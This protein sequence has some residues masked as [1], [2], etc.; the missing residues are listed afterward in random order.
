[1]K[2]SFLFIVRRDGRPLERRLLRLDGGSLHAF[3]AAG[4]LEA[5]FL[6]LLER[7]VSVSLDFGEMRKYVLTAIV[8]RYESEAFCIVE[9]LHSTSCHTTL[10]NKNK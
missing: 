7:L 3:W 5:D 4:D 1:M 8:G 10:L 9:P 2:P 6:L